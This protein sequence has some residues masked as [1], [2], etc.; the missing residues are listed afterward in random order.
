MNLSERMVRYEGR[1]ASSEML[2]RL[3]VR[4][5]VL[6]AA[7]WG[8]CTAVLVWYETGRYCGPLAHQYFT[9]WV[10]AWFFTEPLPVPF[11]SLP[12]AGQRYPVQSVYE[13]LNRT[14]FVA[15]PAAWFEHYAGWGLTPH[16][17]VAAAGLLWFAASR[18]DLPDLSAQRSS[19]T[20][21][22]VRG[23]RLVSARRLNRQL[24]GTGIAVAGVRI[25]RA[26]E[27]EHFLIA[28]ATG[29]GKSVVIR[30][31]LRQIE[32][33][34]ETAVVVDPDCEFAPEFYR[35]ERGDLLLNPL[36]GRC[37]AWSPWD[38]LDPNRSEV[39]AEMLAAA[40]IPDPPG[41]HGEDGSAFFFRQSSRTLI[42]ALLKVAQ[43][44]VPATLPKL[45]NLSRAELR[46]HLAGTPAQ[47]LIDPGA[48]DQGAGIVATA[49]NAIN[50]LRYLSDRRGP[51][52]SAR[53]WSQH[54]RGWLF[55]TSRDDLAAAIMPLLSVWL[56]CT[57]RR[58]L[59]R[60][61]SNEPRRRVWIVVD[62]LSALKRQAQLENLLV[63][64][65]KRDLSAVIGFQT[66]SQLRSI[67]G[68]EQASVLSSMPSTK[69]LLR[70]DEPET[71][72]FL[73]RQIGDREI[74]RDE[75]ATSTGDDRTTLSLHAHRGVEALVLPSEI[76]GLPRLTGY[77]CVA[78]SDRAR[79]TIPL[80]TA[81]PRQPAFLPAADGA[82]APEEP[83]INPPET[84]PRGAGGPLTF[85]TQS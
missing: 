22:H 67:Y 32:R 13:F 48:H 56:D 70:V 71:A 2:L 37:P 9:E 83:S 36:D 29:T 41:P 20:V 19:S 80:C 40:F 78:G 7:V 65:R 60:P 31:M 58:L 43:P 8:A 79:T 23:L 38:E 75:P 10:V 50:P 33:R 76:Q 14:V 85:R 25:P 15:S 30:T 51:H 16:V 84:A 49:A 21:N 3:V 73:S 1:R 69:L 77:L 44:N 11:I 62:E 63:R 64:G 55:L 6:A 5:A 68:R 54:P 35:P 39:D 24:R 45:L 28:G 81:Q 52:W 18:L 82:R 59:A 46:Q 57:V 12:Y 27:P 53:E 47:P 74:Y 72:Q 17:A 34:G 4:A 61:E 26:R 66:I 42:M